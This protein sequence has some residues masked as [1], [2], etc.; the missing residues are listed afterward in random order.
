MD[1]EADNRDGP[2]RGSAALIE[3]MESVNV[4]CLLML[5]DEK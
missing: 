3:L 2:A 5:L 1:G 4:G